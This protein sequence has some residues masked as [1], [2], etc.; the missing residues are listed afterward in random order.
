MEKEAN[1]VRSAL[2]GKD[3]KFVVEF[4]GHGAVYWDELVALYEQQGES[5]RAFIERV[6]H[7]LKEDSSSE[8]A[9]KSTGLERV[10]DIKSWFAKT[11]EAPT[12]NKLS[13]AFFS[14]PLIVLTQAA[15]YLVF[16]DTNKLTHEDVV[17]STACAIGFSQGVVSGAL[18]AAAKTREDYET[19]AVAV[20]RYMFWHGLRAQEAFVDVCVKNE[21]VIEESTP[22]LAVRGLTKA[23]VL[24][25]IEV[26]KRRTRRDG[27]QLSLVHDRNVFSVTGLPSALKAFKRTL[28]GFMAKAG[29]DQLRI[30]YSARKPSGSVNYEP[31]SCPVHSS[32]LGAARALVAEDVERM[33]VVV[34]GSDLQVPMYGTSREAHNLQE[35]GEANILPELIDMQLTSSA[36]WPATWKNVV[37]SRPDATHVIALGPDGVSNTSRAITEGCELEFISHTTKLSSLSSSLGRGVWEIAFGPRVN[38]TTG[39]LENKYTRLLKKDPVMVAGMTP[40]TS[41]NGVNLVAAIQNAGFHGELAG[42]A[43]TEPSIFECAVHELVSK[44]TP[45]LGVSINMLYLN[46]KQWGFQFPMVLRMRKSGVPIESITIGAGIPTK[47]RAIEI[48]A[49]LQEA[50]INLIGLKPVSVDGINAVLEIAS[51]VPTMNVMLQWTGGRAGGHHSF[52]DFHQPLES[53]YAA[54]RRVPNVLLVVGS[55][56]GNWEDSVEYL[57][58]DWSLKRGWLSKMP[59]DGVLLGSRVM[60]AK[61]AA[62]EPEVKQLLVD[63]PGIASELEWEKSYTDIAG[64]IVT[65]TSELG[66][67]IHKV[68]NRCS[69]LWREFDTKYFSKPREEMELAIRLD[70]QSIIERL[71]ADFQK[72]YFG[73]KVD[74]GGETRSAELEEMTYSEV[75]G[76]MIDLMYVEIEGRPRRWLHDSFLDRVVK[77]MSRTEER[78]R[79]AGGRGVFNTSSLE[80]EPRATLQKFL[81]VYP[82]ATMTLLSIP[83]CDYF[84][85]LCQ[86]GGKPVNFVPVIDRDFKTWFKK[87]SL[88]YSEDLDTVPNRDAQRVCILQ[89]P[90]AVRYSTVVD[91][92]VGKILGDIAA[93]FTDVVAKQPG[94]TIKN[95]EDEPLSPRCSKV[96]AGVSVEATPNGYSLKLPKTL[97]EL[98]SHD[99]WFAVLASLADS[100]W[101][102]AVLSSKEVCQ[103]RKWVTNPIRSLLRPQPGQTIRVK[104]DGLL[105]FDE[106]LRSDSEPVIQLAKSADRIVLTLYE[107]RPASSLLDSAVVEYHQYFHYES[108]VAC[109][110]VQ[111][112]D[113]AMS[114]IKAFYARFWVAGKDNEAGSCLEACNSSLTSTFTDEFTVT[115]VDIAQY[116]AALALGHDDSS[117]L[118]DF[119]VVACWKPLVAALF[120]KELPGSLFNLLHLRQSHRLLSTAKA[121]RLFSVG[122][123]VVSK[124]NVSSV[125]IVSNGV[126]VTAVA[127]I[128]RKALGVEMEEVLEPLVQLTT[129]FL[130]RGEFSDYENTFANENS[131]VIVVL[132]RSELVEILLS[133][134][135]YEHSTG[136]LALTIGDT[137]ELVTTTNTRFKSMGTIS[138]ILVSGT[139]YR[140]ANGQQEKV[141]TIQYEGHNVKGSPV[142]LFIDQVNAQA[143]KEG[144]LPNG[145]HFMLAKPLEISVPV[146]AVPYAVASRDLNPIH[147]SKYAATLANLSDGKVVMH[148][149]WTATKV[150]SLLVEHFGGGI[151]T[152]VLVYDVT[153]SRKVYPGETLF[154]QARHV[155][156]KGGHKVLTVEVA[157]R[158]GGIV[159]SARAE[160]K[161]PPT[162]FV[163]TGQGSA[164]VG[165]GMA[166][167]KESPIVREVWDRGDHCLRELYG[168]SI[169]DIVRRNPSSVTVH[170]GGRQGRCIRENYMKLRCD[171]PETGELVPL[172]P[173]INERTP[174]YTFSAPEGLLFSTQFTQPALVLFERA[175]FSELQTAELVPDDAV[176]AGHS[177]GEY[178][179]LCAFAGVFEAAAEVAFIRGTIM[180]NVTKRDEHGRSDYGM[181]AANPS[182]VGEYFTEE[183]LHNVVDTIAEA[184]SKLLQVVNYNVQDSQYVVAG[185]NVN[186]EVLS[187]T[188][189]YLKKNEDA[190]LFAVVAV[191]LKQAREKK[192]K[193]VQAGKPFMVARG[194]ATIPLIGIDVPFHSKAVLSGVPAFRTLLR[195]KFDPETLER[196]LPLL[197]NRYIPNLT[198]TPFS[199]E[200]SYFE[201]VYEVTKSPC[202]AEVLDP[203]QWDLTTKAQRTHVLIVELLTYQSASPVQWI[204]TQQHLFT[205]GKSGVR[206]IVEIGPAPILTNMTG[207][208]LLMGKFQKIP[209]EVLWYQ[210]DRDVVHFQMQ[211]DYSS[212]SEYARSLAVVDVPSTSEVDIAAEECNAPIT[213]TPG[214][215]QVNVTAPVDGAAAPVID[216]PV[217]ALHV[218]RIILAM[219]LSMPLTEVSDDADVKTLSAGKS[220]VQNEIV[221]DLEKEFGDSVPEGAAEL[222]LK[223]VAN[224]F[225]SYKALGKVTSGLISKM[226]AS[227]M[228]G[229]FSMSSVKS[230]LNGTKNLPAGRAESVLA[231]S[232]LFTPQARL[233]SEAEAKQWLDS[234][235]DGYASFAGISLAQPSVVAMGSVPQFAAAPISTPTVNDKPVDAKHALIVLLAAKLGK[236]F[237]EISSDMTIKDLAAGKSAVQNEIVGDL[238]KEFGSGPDDGAEVKLL[239][240]ATKFPGYMSP[241]K[242]TS[243][244]IAKL[245]ASKMPGGF[246]LSPVKAYLSS[247]RCLPAGRIESVLVHSLTQNPKQRFVDEAQAKAWLDSVVDDYAK[248]AGVD[249]PY[250][251]KLDGGGVAMTSQSVGVIPTDFDKRLRELIAG[252]VEALNNYLDHD[253][254]EWHRRIESEVELREHLENSIAVWTKEHE[255]VYTT[256]IK[257]L[258]DSNKERVYD[259]YWN[260]ALQDA[261]AMYHELCSLGNAGSNEGARDFSTVIDSFRACL[262]NRATPA[263]VQI[264]RYM[265][266]KLSDE[267]NSQCGEAVEGL[268]GQ[269]EG[270][271]LIHPVTISRFQSMRAELRILDTGKIKVHQVPRAGVPDAVHYVDDLARG[272]EYWLDKDDVLVECDHESVEEKNRNLKSSMI[273]QSS[274]LRMG[275]EENL[276]KLV[277]PHVHIRQPS[278]AD[279]TLR[280]FD[281]EMTCTLLSC[282]REMAT[283]GVSFYGKVALATG[284]GRD[285]IGIEVVKSLLEG[286]ATV[287]VT[288]SSYSKTTTSMLQSIYQ[289]HGSRGS[290]LITVPFNQG[291][292]EDVHAL[293]DYVYDKQKLDLD[294]V[295]PFAA[296]SEVGRK[297]NEID[298]RSEL[299]HRVMLTN[300]LRLLG[301]V[302]EAKKSRGIATRPALAVVPLSQNHGTIGGEGLYSESKLGLESLINKWYSEDWQD[303]LSVV[304]AVIGWTHGTSLMTNTEIVCTRVEEL[305]M[306]TFSTQETGF[307]VCALLH[308][309]I[310]ALTNDGP[311][312]A[313]LSGG[314]GQIKN[315]KSSMEKIYESI[316]YEA[317]AHAAVCAAAKGEANLRTV[318]D[319]SPSFRPLPRANLSGFFCNEFPDTS[320][321]AK[322]ATTGKQDLLQGMINLREVV[323]VAG[324]GEVGPW[325]SARTRWEMESFGEFSLEGCIELA[326][327]TGRIIYQDG[328]WVDA[329]TKEIVPEHDIKS[330][331]E[332]EILEH[333]GIRVVEPELFD[334]YDPH[335]KLFLHQV[336]TDKKMAPIDVAD[337]E[338]ALEFRNELGK[339]N[340]DMFQNDSGAWMIRLKKGAVVSIPRAISFDRFVAGQIPTGWSAERYGIP[341]DLAQ[342]LDPMTLFALVSTMEAFVAAG[343]TD[344]YEFYQYIHVSEIGNSSGG[345]I[346]GMRSLRRIFGSRVLGKTVPNDTLQECFIN[347]APAW[348]NMLLLSSSGP[349]RTPV[350]A[351][352]TA[353]ESID[354][355]ADTIKA[356]KARV[357]IVG[358]FDDYGEEGAY[359]FAQ[360]KTSSNSAKEVSMGRDPR[361]MCRP[362]TSTRDGFMESHGAGMQLLMDA[363]LAL[364]MGCPIYAVVA[365]ANT[366]T[367]KIG[368][369]PAAPGLG[370]VSTAK[371]DRGNASSKTPL[372]LNADYRRRQFDSEMKSIESWYDCEKEYLGDSDGEFLEDM[373]RRRVRSA[374]KTWGNDFFVGRPDIAPLRGALS[375]WN[376]T[377]DDIG[378]ATFHGTSTKANDKNESEVTQLQFEHLGRTK[379]NVLPVICQKYLTGHPKAPAAA[380]MTNGLL[381]V[382]DT[383]RIPGNK[384][385]D[386]TCST[387]R[388]F[389]FLVYPNES[390]QTTGIKAAILRS[391]G[392][393]QVG[394]EVLFVHPDCLLSTLSADEL[395]GYSHRRDSRLAKMNAYFQKSLCG[396]HTLVQVKDSA[397]YTATQETA[398]LMNPNARAKFNPAANTWLYG[399]SPGDQ[400]ESKSQEEQNRVVPEKDPFPKKAMKA[401]RDETSYLLHTIAQG[402]SEMA[403]SSS[404]KTGLGVDV[405]PIA[406]FENLK[407]RDDFIRRNFTEQEMAYCFS[408][409]S[410]ASSFAGRWAA[411][412]AVVK[413]ISSAAPNESNMCKGASASLREIEIVMTT[414]GAPSVVLSGHAL[415]VF[416]QVG[417]A[418]MTVSISH[419]GDYAVAQALASYDA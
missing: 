139:V 170:F 131:N 258:F 362:C 235:V 29:E 121:D 216:A 392:F 413:A 238:E 122:D 168:F 259:S 87:D 19:L 77:F 377:I 167:Y 61:E 225:S 112:D 96:I 371:E 310:V 175:M 194:V 92:P 142:K 243:A 246:G 15:N 134:S 24:K 156:L 52:E 278:D 50:G 379:G 419:S 35:R 307:N 95:E 152:N 101:L 12:S 302:V 118:A 157:N 360:M 342:S 115:N 372:I 303:H 370:I 171:D 44:I 247:E 10:L 161:Q 155:G 69:L 380:W 190:D 406:T 150:R 11:T 207:R 51:A 260:W 14:Y 345:A 252:Q 275:L 349:I 23:Q 320:C 322:R 186:L 348:V 109:P 337:Y 340:V 271:M 401:T 257:P 198:A 393:G 37:S 91:E 103:S 249:I 197:V 402:A 70:K 261:V 200:K 196:Q 343:I 18:F 300:T 324:F 9:S 250:L 414:S 332:Y 165:M 145:G 46:A 341:K 245:L 169:L 45:G 79:R 16:L 313:D 117:V 204:K 126:I 326:W 218:L 119:A 114:D 105:V 149:M 63:T 351:C 354:I 20:I 285:S 177:L 384:N 270:E 199:L 333:A 241:G 40:T 85:S 398:V 172:L 147:R 82:T 298:G 90:V 323:V 359:E 418:S 104:G 232:L 4:D 233:K 361:E 129:E 388:E 282:M 185:D 284:C 110:V 135:W 386:N 254:L 2:R 334:G 317:K 308:P 26:T 301:E 159:L 273:Q 367:D 281:V 47:E 265:A 336:A 153:F 319:N 228:P 227:K 120:S 276:H 231:H 62:T 97:S 141:G 58:G 237:S 416:S 30:P 329:K 309:D 106:E 1:L 312:W 60:V 213:V 130:V 411:K 208:T 292:A 373:K 75:L 239:D 94:M 6:A 160:V 408:A 209:R 268:A 385:M 297:L 314:M 33:G 206:R 76:R 17:K 174:S 294:F 353:A 71:N 328:N 25:A 382:L 417:L 72:P 355:G 264:V 299:A 38:P 154:M 267:V 217:C 98:P 219:R 88:W 132:D 366:A 205:I 295:V 48:A 296:V 86:T 193:A 183:M 383:G 93:G 325:G 234:C 223:E 390:L 176:F 289:R 412:E 272:L 403:L 404:K 356:G 162:A 357:V 211:N 316:L 262:C 136:V 125:R 55:G 346:G 137:L 318:R 327:L 100:E 189:S 128:S 212:A 266:K 400:R 73:C 240:L 350:G 144:I 5:V 57:T 311:V 214:V 304:G 280:L 27:V 111:V 65:V 164:E 387:L 374:Q 203:M 391:Y 358:G 330:R 34:R 192:K 222:S 64:G 215:A 397:P 338:E 178:A 41:L 43:L 352:A 89:G 263:L 143:A 221:G 83:D 255:E 74:E 248:F 201:K 251:S 291:S 376:L 84:V 123:D 389:D 279:P 344:P 277:L 99:T 8:E 56:F 378:V 28:D 49:Q 394:S 331:Y 107:V 269:V 179:G 113:T 181:V 381:R 182:R 180:Q 224:T 293:I 124:V 163:F 158:V 396:K 407:G 230:Y 188:L 242:V 53:V 415:E 283:S 347:T 151:D 3:F 195:T 116:N 405:E 138:S 288:T 191:A 306:R 42:G 286:G 368:R 140:Q 274:A 409:P 127:L 399:V 363:E 22:M 290:R 395:K 108:N 335:K 67:P 410:P 321:A 36:D 7:A 59:V 220:A 305:G 210:R 173:D 21:E 202:L 102:G 187:T 81:A 253:P 68:A 287:I 80:S 315:L 244:L 78:F 146:S 229:G 166:R 31:V 148:G 236:S 54:I 32:L 364:E 339:E 13:R 256:G 133:K 226:I 375:M 369:S 184:S 365:L 66:E 39:K